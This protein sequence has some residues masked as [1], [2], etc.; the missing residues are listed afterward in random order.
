MKKWKMSRSLTVLEL[1]WTRKVEA[2]KI[3]GTDCKR[4]V[5]HSRNYGRCGQPE[6]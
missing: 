5:V 1:L 2:V 3:L 6:K 4:H